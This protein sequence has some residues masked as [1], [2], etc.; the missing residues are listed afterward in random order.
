MLTFLLT[1]WTAKYTIYAAGWTESVAYFALTY[2]VLKNY[3]NSESFNS[4][5]IATIILGRIIK[6]TAL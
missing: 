3:G 1:F 4:Y 6:P 5:I 2:L